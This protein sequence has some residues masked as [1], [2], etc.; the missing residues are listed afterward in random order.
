[1][2]FNLSTV[3]FHLDREPQFNNLGI[4]LNLKL[5]KERKYTTYKLINNNTE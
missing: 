4:S 1:M 2:N 3:L 5:E